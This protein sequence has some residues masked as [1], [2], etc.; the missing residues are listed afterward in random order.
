MMNQKI[1][2]VDFKNPIIGAS[3][4]FGFGKEY[5]NFYDV[6]QLGAISSKGLTLLPKS[7]N[8]GIRI[9]ET[10]SGIMN[11]IG[12]ENPGIE[13]FLSEELPRM[14]SYNT[15][16]LANVGGSDLE[17]YLE[18]V[19]LIDEASKNGN[20]VD[21]IELNISCP[22]VKQGGMAFGMNPCD[23]EFITSKVRELTK[24]P[25]VVKLSPNAHNLVEVAKAVELAGAD[26]ISL[27]NTFN[28][29]DIDVKKRKA[30]FNNIYAG[31]S[32][33]AIRPIA[34]RMVR[35]VSKN[36][37]VPVIGMGG[38]ET[39]M[40]AAAFIMAGAHLIQFG[41]ASFIDPMAGINIL[42]ELETFMIEEKIQSLDEIRGII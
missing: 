41:T 7:G 11:S 18:A 15:A 4:T 16:I 26:G 25:L 14:K 3:G 13:K 40:D 2:G 39:G 37:S 21:V 30:S 42:K 5:N 34:L 12:L 9:V 20:A 6:S 38:I 10:P 28:A 1:W 35:D 8:E 31:L 19:R 23:A 22:N 17:S 24:L 32:G 33:P 29:L 27:V 36:V